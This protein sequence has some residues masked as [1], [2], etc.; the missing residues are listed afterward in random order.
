MAAYD[1]VASGATAGRARR[2]PAR[3]Q[4][5]AHATH[6]PATMAKPIH[7]APS[8]RR[9]AVTRENARRL[10]RAIVATANTVRDGGGQLPPRFWSSLFW[11]PL[12][13]RWFRNTSATVRAPR[14]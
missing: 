9:S 10:A 12:L 7:P 1:G 3:H 2:G 13:L 6:A 11:S 5:T 8:A 14:R 4:P